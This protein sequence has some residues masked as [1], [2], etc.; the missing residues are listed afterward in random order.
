MA[1]K[2]E[3]IHAMVEPEVID[4]VHKLKGRETLSSYVRRV[5]VRHCNRHMEE[6]ETPIEE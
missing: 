4:K 3:I 2:T 1:K 5:L 6:G